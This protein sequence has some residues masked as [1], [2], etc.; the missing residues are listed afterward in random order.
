[1]YGSKRAHISRLEEDALAYVPVELLKCVVFLGYKDQS[2]QFRVAG[3]AFWVSRQ[4]PTDIQDVYRPAYL[5]TAGHVIDYIT[6]KSA[7][8]DP[9]V[10]M[11]VNIRESQGVWKDVYNGCW[12][13]HSDRAADVAVL[14]IGL[15][16]DLDHAA[17]P[18]EMSVNA[19]TLRANNYTVEH[20]DEVFFSG[21]FWP[22]KG[23]LKNTPIVRVGNVAAL[24]DERVSTTFGPSDAYLIDAHSIGGFSGSPVFIDTIAAKRERELATSPFLGPSRFLLFGLMHGHYGVPNEGSE[25]IVDSGS[26]EEKANTGISIV[27]PAERIAEVIESSFGVEEQ[28]EIKACRDRKKSGVIEVG[29]YTGPT[30]NVTVQTTQSGVVIPASTRKQPERQ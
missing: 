9:R 4:G 15:D 17:W 10:W 20:G 29:M 16:A 2:D 6:K 12:K 7:A 27:I 8:T 13:F 30:S 11:R 3:S 14:K 22:H 5:A 26:G 24:R 19:E 25:I 1:M 18:L 23:N 28:E 21:L